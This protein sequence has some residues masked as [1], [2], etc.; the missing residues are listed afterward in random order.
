MI[1][2]PVSYGKEFF[3]VARSDPQYRAIP[4]SPCYSSLEEAEAWF[5]DHEG[6]MDMALASAQFFDR[7]E[8]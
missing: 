4:I 7:P 5:G 6:E 1:V 2:D 3:F 8:A